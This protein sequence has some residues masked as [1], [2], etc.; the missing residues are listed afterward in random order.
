ML[1]LLTLYSRGGYIFVIKGFK[2]LNVILGLNFAH[3]VTHGH[4]W[5]QNKYAIVFKDQTVY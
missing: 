3:V 1:I 5:G 2:G 4:F